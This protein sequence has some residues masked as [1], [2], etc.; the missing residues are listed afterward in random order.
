MVLHVVALECRRRRVRHVARDGRVV[1]L[2]PE[3]SK[4]KS[5]EA[6]R[7]IVMEAGRKDQSRTEKSMN[8]SRLLLCAENLDVAAPHTLTVLLQRKVHLR[9]ARCDA[10]DQP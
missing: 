8:T 1:V 4:C 10:R 3:R 7:A 9:S 2:A 6:E 5:V